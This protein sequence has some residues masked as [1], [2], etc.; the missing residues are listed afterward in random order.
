VAYR[1]RIGGRS[2][3]AGTLRGSLRAGLK[4]ISTFARVAVEP[5]RARAP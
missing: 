2:K 1:R 4:I 5:A 3:V